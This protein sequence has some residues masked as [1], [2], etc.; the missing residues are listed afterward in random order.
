[1]KWASAAEFKGLQCLAKHTANAL[2]FPITTT[3]A[4]GSF[5]ILKGLLTPQH[6]YMDPDTRIG[7]HC[8]INHLYIINGDVTQRIPQW[9]RE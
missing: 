3:V 4:E 2:T 8:I 5:R 7:Y 6:R 1:M 9:A